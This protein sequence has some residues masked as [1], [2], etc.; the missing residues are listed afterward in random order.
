MESTN[1]KFGHVQTFDVKFVSWFVH[2]E[3]CYMPFHQYIICFALLDT[4]K[5]WL[6]MRQRLDKL[7]F[8]F[9]HCPGSSQGESSSA[10]LVLRWP[11]LQCM[12]FRDSFFPIVYSK[13]RGMEDPHFLLH[14]D[15]KVS[16]KFDRCRVV[17]RRNAGNWMA[18]GFLCEFHL[19][20]ARL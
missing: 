9:H 14:L 16:K 17:C 4:F 18:T 20:S 6:L 7:R 15:V 19:K 5:P 13:C 2:R 1:T 3:G 10:I 8:W 12:P 11:D